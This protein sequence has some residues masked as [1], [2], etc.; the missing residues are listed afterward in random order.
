MRRTRILILLVLS[1]SLMVAAVPGQAQSK[2]LHWEQYDVFLNVLPNGDLRVTERQTINFTQGTFTFGFAVIPL[3]KTAGITN[4]SVSEP[5]GR[6]YTQTDYSIE[7][8]TFWTQQSGDE[9]EIRWYFPPTGN[10]IRTFDL[11]YT[12]QG[13]VRIYESGDKLQWIAIDNERDFPVENSTVT[14]TLPEGASFLDIDSAGVEAEWQQGD[15]GRSVRYVAQ[16]PLSPSDTFEIGVEFT[17]GVIPADE[18]AWQAAYDRETYYD[19]NVRPILNLGVGALA[20]LIALG[21]PI[22]VYILWYTRGRDPEVGPVPERLSEKPS[23]MPPG[24]LGSLIDEKADM[25]DIVATIVD[26]ARRGYMTIEEKEEKG[27][28]GLGSQDFVYHRTDKSDDD[29]LSYERRV[30]NGI[31]TGSRTERKLSD[32]RNK[33]YTKLPKIQEDLYEELVE[34]DLFKRRPD[35]VRGLWTGLGILGLVIAFVGSFVL[36]PL[37]QYAGAFP[38]LA[39]AL[40]VGGVSILVASRFMP[41]KSVEGSEAAAKWEAF[42]N[43]MRE[44]RDLEE[45]ENAG[46][47]FERYLPYAIAFG[48]NQSFVNKFARVKNAPGPGWYVPYPRRGL[49]TSGGGRG[50]AGDM[51]PGAGAGRGGLQGM[52]E[53]MSGGLQSMSDGLTSMLNSTGRILGSAPSSSGSSGGGGGGFSGGGFSGGGGGGGGSRGFG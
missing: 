11:S 46:E 8:Y 26:L 48:M 37:S 52:S 25:Q 39:V 45:L 32:L 38:C 7:P 14:V 13:A 12:V 23:D 33:F 18:P 6:V 27:I 15:G 20:V 10:A 24:L 22:L 35:R 19:E 4:V 34:Q 3:D 51:E 9:T 43:Y 5:E 42:R 47:I 40:G 41:A 28:F 1:I 44:L 30:L 36:I 2:T 49:S 50:L 31:F 17:N 16:R 53:S 29:L 21:G